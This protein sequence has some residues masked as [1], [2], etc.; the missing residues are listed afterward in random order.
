MA[1]SKVT[2]GGYR[3][4]DAR[5]YQIL[6]NY[7]SSKSVAQHITLTTALTTQLDESLV[8]DRIVLIGV[9]AASIDDSFYTP[10]S[11]GKR[12]N[13]TMPGVIVHAQLVSQILS[14]VLDERS[15]IWFWP[16]WG[17]VLWI[18]GWSLVGT[19][20]ALRLRHPGYL[21]LAESAALAILFAVYWLLFLAGG[22]IPLV[23]SALGL[24]TASIGIMVYSTYQTQQDQKKIL[25][26]VQE[27]EKNITLLQTLLQEKSPIVTQLATKPLDQAITT[28]YVR[29]N[30]P[31]DENSNQEE[32]LGESS[33]SES[34]L[35]CDRY[36][37]LRVLG[38]GGFGITYLVEDTHITGNP[39]SVVKHLQPARTDERFMQIARRLFDTEVKILGQLGHH[40]QIPHLLNSFEENN[41]FYLV[42]EFID[43]HPLNEELPVDRCLPEAQVIEMLKGVLEVLI[44]IH[45]RHIIHRDIKPSNIIRRHQD[46]RLVLIDFGAVKQMQPQVVQDQQDRTV[47]IGTRGYAPPEQ[48]AGKPGFS[49]DIYALGMIGI[50][51]VT[52]IHPHE[53]PADSNTGDIIWQDLASVRPEFAQILE[54][55]VYYHF[56]ERYQSATAVLQ[57]LQRL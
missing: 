53:L 5:G 55:M 38:V 6:L 27:Q 43:G 19:A 10:Y 33:L 12:R 36:Q 17:E 4:I 26:Q 49:S 52:G 48:Y 47:A 50:Q 22:W 3:Q 1:I 30:L 14:A 13:Q 37:I 15:L 54:K 46:Q 16:E 57:D 56:P 32:N 23:P 18:W 44:F 45:E 24:V 8:K 39:Q 41:K 31:I 7:R 25:L 34:S 29:P 28:L 20:I 21:L 51:A 9:N 2:A 11:S 42:E 40:P 35:I